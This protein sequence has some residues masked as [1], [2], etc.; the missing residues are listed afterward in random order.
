[1]F[2]NDLLQKDLITY[3]P[4][5][6]SQRLKAV[7][8]VAAALQGSK[9]LTI[10]AIGRCLKSEVDIKHR[11]KK[12]DRLIGNKHLYNELESLYIGLSQ[13]VFKY[14][15]QDKNI[16]IIIDLCFLKDAHDIQMLSAEVATKGRSIPL[17][18]EVFEI[19]KLKG[20]AKNFLSKL[21]NCLPSNRSVLIIMDAGFGDDWFE[22]IESQN[23]HWL[24]RARSGKNIKLSENEDWHDATELFSKASP[25]AKNYPKAFITKDQNRP[26]RV[27]T[28]QGT[29]KSKRKR[30]FKLPRNY[31]S[32]NGNY[33]RLAKEPW[34][35]ATNLPEEYNATQVVQ[36]YKKRMQIEES[37]RDIKSHQFG[38]GARN[39][40]TRCIFRWGIKMLLAA[41]VQITLWVIGIIGHSKGFQRKF[42]ANTVKDKKVFSYFYLG[43]LIVEHGK[44][45]E[46]NIDYENLQSTIENELA[47]IW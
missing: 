24:V 26:C 40:R 10:T 3:C 7:L 46:L 1:M 34:I 33:Q 38:L 30:P 15:S 14:I 47:R 16:P 13:Y 35:L 9:N 8:D 41:I 12:V 5:I 39:I 27:I 6:H 37:F 20:K 18:R 4:E 29:S 36:Y 19:N 31:N 25:R 23:W 28:K 44:L 32:A 43:Q 22:A 2:A 11:I 21:S 17:Y 45:D 42:Q